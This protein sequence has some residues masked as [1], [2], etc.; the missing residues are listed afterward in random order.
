MH[1]SCIAHLLMSAR[2]HNTTCTSRR[3]N[4]SD[5]DPKKRR[6]CIFP[7]HDTWKHTNCLSEQTSQKPCNCSVRDQIQPPHSFPK[8]KNTAPA[9]APNEK[10][11]LAD[12]KTIDVDHHPCHTEYQNNRCEI[13]H[14]A[15]RAQPNLDAH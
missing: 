14:R 2:I 12:R 11:A 13:R 1:N 10:V 8:P 7:A 6:P 4:N 9:W 5:I 3:K 15:P